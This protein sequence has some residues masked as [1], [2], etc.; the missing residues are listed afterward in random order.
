MV[1]LIIPIIPMNS[2]ARKLLT[3]MEISLR[4]S[5]GRSLLSA[6]SAMARTMLQSAQIGRSQIAIFILFKMK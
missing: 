4:I 1:L 3:I 6:E 5:N 2:R